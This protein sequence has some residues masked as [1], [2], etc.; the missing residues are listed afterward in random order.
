MSSLPRIQSTPVGLFARVS[1]LAVSLLL[2]AGALGG[3]AGDGAANRPAHLSN[4]TPE[5]VAKLATWN[6]ERVT[7]IANE[8][9]PAINDVYVSVTT[10]QTGSQIGSGQANAFLRLKDRVR[11]ARNESRH[12]ATMLKDGQGRTDTVHSYMRLMTVVRD[13]R[14]DARKMFL[15]APTMDKIAQA[16]DLLRRLSPY[17]DPQSNANAGA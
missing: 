11:V 8:L 16:A 14:T 13:A 10:L 3:C 7:A 5:Q 1:L 6:Q 15:E 4:L 9:T 2:A 12:L 17:Y